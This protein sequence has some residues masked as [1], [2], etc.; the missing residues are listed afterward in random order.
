MSNEE[1]NF[2]TQKEKDKLAK[3]RR[4]RQLKALQEQE[5]KDIAA[6]L[7]TSDEVA[8]EALAL[9]ID[10]ATAPVLPLIPLIEVAW[11]DGSL[12]QKESEA[13]LEAARN[14]GIKN[15]A[16]LEFIELLLSKKPS[17][18]FFDRINRVIAAMVQE[19][20]GDAGS[21]ILE[22]AKAVAEASGGFFG[23]TNSVSDEEKELLDNFAKMFGIK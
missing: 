22:Q 1:S 20:G 23:L 8:A 12:S 18:L 3:E 11:A 7:N 5:Q 15:P 6:T 17:Q 21:T 4:E 13:V 10:A 2:I 9:G 16:A 14:K 19:H